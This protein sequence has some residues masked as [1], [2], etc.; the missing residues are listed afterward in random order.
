MLFAEGCRTLQVR[1]SA[2]CGCEG[3]CQTIIGTRTAGSTRCD[4]RHCGSLKVLKR[5]VIGAR[6]EHSDVI[7]DAY[8]HCGL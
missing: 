4:W 8:R 1:A 5:A 2:S 7:N 6:E 3:A